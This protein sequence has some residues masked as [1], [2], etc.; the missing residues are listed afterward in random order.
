M[1][2]AT[3][4]LP[5]EAEQCQCE[6]LNVRTIS[7]CCDSLA[8]R[9]A[10]GSSIYIS[11]LIAL[12]SSYFVIMI[13]FDTSTLILIAKADLLDLFLTSINVPVAI[14]SEAETE[15]CGSNTACDAIIR[16]QAL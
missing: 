14:P 8:V 2:F 4:W 16:Q 1:R 6:L 3:E 12:R 7:L 11:F 5:R 15:C 13:V 10:F 9:N